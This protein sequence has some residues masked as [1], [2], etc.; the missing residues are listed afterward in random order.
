MFALAVP[1]EHRVYG[2]EIAAY[3]VADGTVSAQDILDH[4]AARLDFAHQPKVVIFG[5][6][7]PYTATGKAKRI[8]LKNRLAKELAQYR[9]TSFRRPKPSQAAHEPR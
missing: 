4:C 9:E 6:D 3:V 7:V 2:D 1:F 5:D 8:E